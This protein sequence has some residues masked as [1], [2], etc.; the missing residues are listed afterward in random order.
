MSRTTVATI[1]LTVPIFFLSCLVRRLE[2]QVTQLDYVKSEF[3][4]KNTTDKVELMLE[5]KS[6][7]R[8]MEAMSR[9]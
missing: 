9:N 6:I 5:K 2:S 4:I 7:Q 3:R 8:T 1:P